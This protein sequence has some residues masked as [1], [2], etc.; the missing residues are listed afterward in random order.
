MPAYAGEALNEQKEYNPRTASMVIGGV[1]LIDTAQ[2]SVT[3][4]KGHG[5]TKTLDQNGVI[6]DN[7]PTVEGTG[8]VHATSQ[9]IDRLLSLWAESTTFDVTFS[10]AEDSGENQ[11]DF[12]GCRIQDWDRDPV[13][14][15]S[16]PVVTFN[17]EGLDMTV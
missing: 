9:N 12:I 2:I 1:T 11:H 16:L 7:V 17:W 5:F 13:E 6:V 14:V 15:D 3:G 10:P 4:D 8:A